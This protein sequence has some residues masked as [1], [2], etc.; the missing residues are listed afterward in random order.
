ME[1]DGNRADTLVGVVS[2]RRGR[3]VQKITRVWTPSEATAGEE[4]HRLISQFS[5]AYGVGVAVCPVVNAPGRRWQRDGFFITVFPD[6]RRSEVIEKFE[7][8]VPSDSSSCPGLP[9]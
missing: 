5:K 8:G 2:A 6:P 9:D 3:D 7:V 1:C 4:A